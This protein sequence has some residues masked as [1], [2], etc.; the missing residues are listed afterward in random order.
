MTRE[1]GG[2]HS[3]ATHYMRST[4]EPPSSESINQQ[5]TYS[6]RHASEMGLFK[7]TSNLLSG[8]HSIAY[9]RHG[10]IF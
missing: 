9:E 6:N 5:L 4:V 3:R 7:I 1:G 10:E 8:L 2:M